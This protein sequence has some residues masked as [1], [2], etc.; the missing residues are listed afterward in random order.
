MSQ[1]ERPVVFDDDNPQWTEDDFARA[2]RGDA[3]PAAIREAFGKG[4]RGRPVGSTKADAKKPLTLRLDPDV[5]DGWRASGPGWQTR[6]NE[7][8]RD[9][10]KKKSA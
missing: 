6:M 4:R 9:A 5:I 2:L 8:L 10:L 3:I 1:D 7:A